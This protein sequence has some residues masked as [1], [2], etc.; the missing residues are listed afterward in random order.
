MRTTAAKEDTEAIAI[1]AGRYLATVTAPA[2]IAAAV[3]PVLRDMIRPSPHPRGASIDIRTEGRGLRIAVDGRRWDPGPDQ[4]V[5]DQLIY[6]LMRASLDAEPGLLHLHAAYAALGGR[7]LVIAGMPGSGK[8]TLVARMVSQ[9]FDYLTDE[10]VGIDRFLALVPLLK[11][12]SLVEGSFGPLRHLDPRVTGNGA[13]SHR[14]WHVPASAIRPGS[15]VDHADTVAVAF[16]EYRPGAAVKVA[17]VHPAEAVRQL[18]ADSLDAVRFGAGAVPLVARLCATLRCVQLSYG[19]GDEVIAALR[20]L[21]TA[22]RPAPAADVVRVGRPGRGR[23]VVGRP[24]AITPASVPRMGADISGVVVRGRAVLHR[25]ATG[26]IIQLDE[27]NTAW[28]LLVDGETSLGRIAAEVAE[29]NGLSP[30]GVVEL[31]AGVLRELAAL[32][33]VE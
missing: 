31:G 1:A 7:G 10:R 23:S 24:A 11:P 19:D 12:I 30:D 6:V 9:G 16:V 18:L 33:I 14:L 5:C 20:R 8:S 3:R 21:M 32:G 25:G 2:E 4:N 17:D 26:E 22:P 29:A 13:G 15:V 27:T 28:L